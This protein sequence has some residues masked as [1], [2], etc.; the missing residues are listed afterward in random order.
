MFFQTT[1]KNQ[2]PLATGRFLELQGIST[3]LKVEFCLFALIGFVFTAF[4][5]VVWF[6]PEHIPKNF[7]GLLHIFD[8]LLF[9]TL[10]YIVWHHIL[11]E[12]FS[13]YI[14]SYI[15]CPVPQPVLDMT[16]RVA[17]CTAYVPGAE[18]YDILEKT[19][20]A[21]VAVD[22]AH[23]T[24]LLDEG[25]DPE[26]KRICAEYGVHHFSRHGKEEFNGLTGRF[27][28]K[29]KG[30]NY[31]SWLH[32]YSDRYDIVAQHDVDFIPRKDFLTKTLGYFSDPTVAFVGTPQV[33]GN[34]EESWIARGAA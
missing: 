25:N 16:L 29:T 32:H 28:R 12:L 21:M 17:Y 13:W 26:A 5:A 23:D 11:T 20:K 2:S 1:A 9:F 30:G 4:F 34:E 19:L 22:Y 31:N 33:Y 10:S 7:H 18:Q 8:Y 15:Q 14:T 27:K 6:A 24:W 3:L